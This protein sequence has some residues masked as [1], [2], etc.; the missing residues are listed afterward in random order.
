MTRLVCRDV[1]AEEGDKLAKALL[2]QF[3]PDSLIQAASNRSGAGFVD[4]LATELYLNLS[5]QLSVQDWKTVASVLARPGKKAV[6]EKTWERFLEIFRKK[7]PPTAALGLSE[8]LADVVGTDCEPAAVLSFN[9]EPLLFALINAVTWERATNA[10]RKLPAKGANREFFDVVTRSIS[11]RKVDRVPFVFCHGVLPVP[12][13][14]AV[15][16][17]T[18]LDKLV[19]SESDYLQLANNA[20]SW[21]ASAFL[22]ACSS[23]RVLFLGVS[24]S[25]PNMR[26]WLSWT[27][28]NR[29]RELA[30]I[31]DGYHG[32]S[33]FHYW[34]RK[35][36]SSIEEMRWIEASVQHFGIR[37]VWLDDWDQAPVTLRRMLRLRTGSR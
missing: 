21:Q 3:S 24:L 15:A 29:L 27:H 34:L 17:M 19:F 12:G 35:R 20:Y 7:L 25:D 33:T 18:A 16:G 1:P 26:R 9:A 13:Q 4:T 2:R 31:N 8:V 5:S 23:R 32:P 37:L 30:I 36:P 22:D 11:G 10:G 14:K 28:S 6:S